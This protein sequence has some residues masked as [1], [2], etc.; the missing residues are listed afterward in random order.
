M[1]TLKEA[2]ND[3]SEI[4]TPEWLRQEDDFEI[5]LGYTASSKPAKV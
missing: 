5:F 2:G 4:P 1:V 3:T